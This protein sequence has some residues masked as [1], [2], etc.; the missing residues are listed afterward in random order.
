MP[1]SAFRSLIE[2][3]VEAVLVHAGFAAGQWSVDNA[4]VIFYAAAH[5]YIRRHPD[6]VD[7]GHQWGDAYCID[8]TIEG[9]VDG[10]ITRFDVEFEPLAD[11][12]ARTGTTTTPQCSGPSSGSTSQTKTSNASP[13]KVIP[14]DMPAAGIQRSKPA[15]LSASDPAVPRSRSSGEGVR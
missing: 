2:T 4:G 11:L 3:H 6:L 7:D 1:P 13:G 15:R 8:I 14:P 12:L 9:P 5:D 10:G